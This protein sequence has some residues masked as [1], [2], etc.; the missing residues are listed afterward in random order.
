M[1]K[2][3]LIRLYSH[4]LKLY[5]DRFLDEFGGEMGCVFAQALSALDESGTPP[6]VRRVK[7]A[8]LFFREV[9]Y[10]P[11]AYL[12]ARRY[13]VSSGA[14]E[15][16]A[17]GAAY[18]EGQVSETW[19]GRRASWGE[20]L[21]GSLPFLLFGLA[22]LLDGFAEL[23]VYHYPTFNLLGFSPDLPTIPFTAP[24]GVYFVSVLGLL[25]GV[26]KGFPRWSYAYLGISLYFGLNYFNGSFGGVDYSS[27]AWFPTL[28]AIILGLLL[29]RSLQALVRL[30]Q[31]AWNDWTRLS[32]ALYAF[33]LPML[34]IIFF[35]D[36]WGA[37]Q[38]YGLVFDTVLLAAGS[39]VFL[40]SRTTWSR[41]LSLLAVVLILVIKGTM[42]GGWFGGNLRP[43]YWPGFLFII[44]YFGF[45][46]LPAL[47]GL[48][49]LGVQALSSR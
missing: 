11:L 20:A 34:T 32:F 31:G 29:T 26:L 35:D 33:A 5:P 22:H 43:P 21:I 48:L 14:G 1:L 30:L 19:M 47:I 44:I 24:M 3:L 45:L 39:V 2:R 18:G 46:L 12:D 6:A 7:M 37:L 41:V 10:F 23:G 9:W 28:A 25:F 38:L 42:L 27:W 40:R 13:Q 17:V 16:P 8:R 4:L 36:D 15:T 49:R